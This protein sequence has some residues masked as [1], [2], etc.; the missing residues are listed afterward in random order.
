MNKHERKSL[1]A[2]K[3]NFKHAPNSWPREQHSL[4]FQCD[5]VIF[6]LT[7]SPHL[8][9][10]QQPELVLVLILPLVVSFAVR[11][12]VVSIIICLGYC[13]C[14]LARLRFICDVFFDFPGIPVA[15]VRCARRIK[16][17]VL[18]IKAEIDLAAAQT[19]SVRGGAGRITC[20]QQKVN[21]TLVTLINMY[22]MGLLWKGI[23]IQW[24]LI[25][26]QLTQCL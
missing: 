23:H 2:F 14:L 24:H 10:L 4:L 5:W 12:R 25:N 16:S 26:P 17:V 9:M 21:A 18:A 13:C 22:K 11:V 1:S 15:W 19:L 7:C 8:F 20:C 6:W 3:I